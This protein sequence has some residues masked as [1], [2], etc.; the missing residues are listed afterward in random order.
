MATASS[1]F[2]ANTRY[3]FVSHLYAALVRNKIKTYTRTVNQN[4]RMQSCEQYFLSS[5]F[6]IREL[7]FFHLVLMLM[8]KE[9]N[10][11]IVIP[12]FYHVDPAHVRKQLG[13][14]HKCQKD[15]CSEAISFSGSRIIVTTRY[16]QMLTYSGADAI[17]QVRKVE[18]D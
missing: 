2:T 10:K 5:F 14:C 1:S 12:V 13:D 4:F 15:F 8:C 18:S 6:S 16:M 9:R 11:Q 7:C 17:Y 3:N